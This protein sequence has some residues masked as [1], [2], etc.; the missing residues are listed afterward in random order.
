MI[1]HLA[2]SS[3]LF[4]I[5]WISWSTRTWFNVLIKFLLFG[6]MAWSAGLLMTYQGWLIKL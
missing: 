6:M 1:W 2:I 5:L 3:L 4:G